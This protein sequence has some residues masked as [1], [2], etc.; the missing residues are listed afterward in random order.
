MLSGCELKHCLHSC[1]SGEE[2]NVCI[3]KH[4]P[5][6]LAEG[7]GGGGCV[8]AGETAFMAVYI[9]ADNRF[10]ISLICL[11]LWIGCIECTG[12]FCTS[13]LKT[14]TGLENCGVYKPFFQVLVL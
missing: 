13:S 3:L 12:T 9:N 5:Q 4:I 14:G 7:G 6:L 1:G 11:A 10:A 2:G 8:V